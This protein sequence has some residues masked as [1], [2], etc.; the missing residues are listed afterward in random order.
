[1]PT[2]TD[3]NQAV[4]NMVEAGV[5]MYEICGIDGME[6]ITCWIWRNGS[7]MAELQQITPFRTFQGNASF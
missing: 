2:T 6:E 1:M 3:E 7:E 4:E 5:L